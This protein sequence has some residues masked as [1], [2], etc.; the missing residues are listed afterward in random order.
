MNE[1]LDKKDVSQKQCCNHIKIKN[2][3]L[4]FNPST[5]VNKHLS[6]QLNYINY[7]FTSRT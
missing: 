6:L 1:Q 7:I 5:F 3:L 2:D 4:C